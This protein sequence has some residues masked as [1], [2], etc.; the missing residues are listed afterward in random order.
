MHPIDDHVH[1][2]KHSKEVHHACK[3]TAIVLLLG[4]P[5]MQLQL[6]SIA[7]LGTSPSA[8]GRT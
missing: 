6:N 5:S 3:M 1:P 7:I 8:S 2:R 4:W